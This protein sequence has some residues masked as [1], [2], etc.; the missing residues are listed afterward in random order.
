MEHRW[1]IRHS[2]NR[3]VSFAL[4]SGK[5]GE[6]RVLNISSTGAYL[7]TDVLLR[8]LTFIE[9]RVIGIFVPGGARFLACVVRRDQR[10]VGLEWEA[11]MRTTTQSDLLAEQT[12]DTT[13]DVNERCRPA[14]MI[15]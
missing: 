3:A 12:A 5:L 2:T 13:A 14:W 1:G 11:P 7:Q 4:P 10:G 9:V 15:S 8:V 6:G